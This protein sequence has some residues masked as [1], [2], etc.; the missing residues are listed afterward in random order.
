MTFFSEVNFWLKAYRAPKRKEKEPKRHGLRKIR[1][2]SL[3][4]F[5]LTCIC[6]ATQNFYDNTALDFTMLH[7]ETK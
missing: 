3:E 1:Q 4:D 7:K 6:G 5:G 2:P